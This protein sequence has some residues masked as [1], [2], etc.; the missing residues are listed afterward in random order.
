MMSMS[1][2]FGL[3][4]QGW[5]AVRHERQDHRNRDRGA[6]VRG[7]HSVGGFMNQPKPCDLRAFLKIQWPFP[8]KT[9]FIELDG[10]TLVRLIRIAQNREVFRNVQ[11]R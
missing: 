4:S 3:R 2:S 9:K 8:P 7:N 5:K 1:G 6:F 11:A 10:V